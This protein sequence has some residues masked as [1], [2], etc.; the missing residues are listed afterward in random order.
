[1]SS[2]SIIKADITNNKSDILSILIN[3]L[4][5]ASEERYLWNYERN[6]YGKAHNWLAKEDISGEYVGSG[7]LFPRKLY[8]NGKPVVVAIAG[9]FVV[10]NLN[11]VVMVVDLDNNAINSQ[12]AHVNSEKYYE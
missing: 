9:D 4:P 12:H 5:S 11:I 3:N 7:T 8:L 6:P 2:Y 1:M 10:D